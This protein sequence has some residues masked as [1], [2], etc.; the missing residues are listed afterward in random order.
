MEMATRKNILMNYLEAIIQL[1]SLISDN[2]CEE[3]IDSYKN[4]KLEDLPV[5][6]DVDKN[7][8]N[9]LGYTI[10][11]KKEPFNKI[12]KEIE[13]LC[14]YYRAK[15]PII[16]TNRIDQVD[17]LKYEVGGKYEYHIDDYTDYSRSISVIVNLNEEYEGGDLIFGDQRKFEVKRCK[18]KKGS[19]VFFP[20]NFLYPHKIEPITKGTRYSIVTWIH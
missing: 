19:I 17:L 10:G 1:D 14:I 4:F 9:V 6:H 18:L 15:F 3:I 12:K 20:S 11:P 16:V 5:H 13:K 2:F 7:E 8:R